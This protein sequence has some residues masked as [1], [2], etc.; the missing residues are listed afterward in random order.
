MCSVDDGVENARHNEDRPEDEDCEG[1][2]WKDEQAEALP[3]NGEGFAGK[4]E[5]ETHGTIIGLQI[6]LHELFMKAD[7]YIAL[8]RHWGQRRKPRLDGIKG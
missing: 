4:V 7:H 8:L 2:A 5:R 3:E 1:Y 6:A